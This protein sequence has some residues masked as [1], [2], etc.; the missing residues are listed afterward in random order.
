MSGMRVV[1][2]GG[3]GFVGSHLCERLLA[4]G[5]EVIA[6]D[7]FTTGSPRN[8]AHLRRNGRFTL[9]EHDVTRPY[10]Y[11]VD[12]IYNLA[13]PA[14]PPHYQADPV[15]TT[16]ISVLGAYHGLSLARRVGARFFQAST[17][18]VY[19]DPEVHPQPEAYR[20][21]VNPIGPRACY[22]EG[23]RCAESLAMDF[24][25]RY[26]VEVRL[27]RIF[28]TY[29]PRM[30]LD[31]GRVVSNF[32]AQALRGEDI[33]IYGDGS[34][35]R[36]FCFVEELVDGIVRF[37]EHPTEIGPL[38]LGNPGEFTIRELAEM[39][40]SLVGGR[41]RLVF[42]PLPEDDPRLRRPDISRARA[43]IGFDPQ[44]RLRDGLIRTIDAFRTELMPECLPAAV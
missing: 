1:V 42:E 19:G 10:N 12:R 28:N 21:C 4:D 41:S 11:R 36:S 43:V 32:I 6:V 22:D 24:H 34:Q 29:G 5:H 9:I 18:E 7:D 30:A 31:D 35:T 2:T 16:M 25:R 27:A 39:V 23:K 38:N 13:C 14:S 37:V 44:I 3:A 33:T 26:A 17:S 8:V 20:G 15:R 40:I